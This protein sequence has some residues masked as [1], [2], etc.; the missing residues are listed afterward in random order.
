M[1][2]PGATARAP[3]RRAVLGAQLEHAHDQ[4][5]RDRDPDRPPGGRQRTDQAGEPVHAALE[6]HERAERGE[7]EQGVGVHRP[8]Q[9]ERVRVEHEDGERRHGARAR[10]AP[11]HPPPEQQHGRRARGD[12]DE[13]AGHLVVV[14]HPTQASH[15]ERVGREEGDGGLL[16]GHVAVARG[17][18]AVVPAGVVLEPAVQPRRPLQDRLLSP[19]AARGYTDHRGEQDR[20]RGEHRKHRD[21]RERRDGDGRR[22]LGARYRSHWSPLATAADAPR[23]SDSLRSRGGAPGYPRPRSARSVACRWP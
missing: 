4:A 1:A 22:S 9:E 7:Q 14:E 20:E 18:D 13:R 19:D 11:P 16:P 2:R 8:V 15:R 12:P 6:Q 23:R 5:D 3:V 21:P 17:R 10:Q